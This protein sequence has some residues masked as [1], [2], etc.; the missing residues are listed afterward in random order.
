MSPFESES[1]IAAQLAPLITVELMPYFLNRPF[2]WA[3]TIGEQSVSAMMPKRRSATSGAL[4]AA[5]DAL[6]LAPGAAEAWDLLQPPSAAAA[7]SPSAA[8]TNSRRCMVFFMGSSVWLATLRT[9]AA[10]RAE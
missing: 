1:R 9:R 8:P 7:P 2:S 6:E 5:E 10:D 3:I 4:L